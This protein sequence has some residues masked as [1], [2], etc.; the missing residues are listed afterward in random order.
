M[1]AEVPLSRPP[2]AATA[3]ATA[4][5]C[6][7]TACARTT[8]T[9]SPVEVAQTRLLSLVWSQILFPWTEF[10]WLQRTCWRRDSGLGFTLFCLETQVS[11]FLFLG[12]WHVQRT[13]YIFS[14][15]FVYI[16]KMVWLVLQK[17]PNL[18]F[19][20]WKILHLPFWSSECV[21]VCVNEWSFT[22]NC[23]TISLHIDTS[24]KAIEYFM[25]SGCCWN[26]FLGLEEPGD[27][28][29]SQR[30]LLG[31]SKWD[32]LSCPRHRER[33]KSCPHGLGGLPV[34]LKAQ[35]CI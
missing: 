28:H 18:V 29:S 26:V 2:T 14:C 24:G 1:R 31:H 33:N 10:G 16:K 25:F 23:T 8:A 30:E 5:W 4:A 32:V 13:K 9:P 12:K 15:T 17:P 6:P 20:I 3:A 7:P 27:T 35:I 11:F 22:L 19:W 21:C 34:L